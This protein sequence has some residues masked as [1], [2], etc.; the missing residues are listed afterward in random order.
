MDYLLNCLPPSWAKWLVPSH[1]SVL[2]K[3]SLNICRMNS[4]KKVLR[5]FSRRHASP[6]DRTDRPVNNPTRSQHDKPMSSQESH[7][8]AWVALRK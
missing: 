5:D 6:P 7:T 2:H 4:S 8:G 1:Y 3:Y